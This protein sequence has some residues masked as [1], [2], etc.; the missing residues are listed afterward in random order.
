M[1]DTH[2][3]LSHIVRVEP[4]HRTCTYHQTFLKYFSHSLIKLK[5]IFVLLDVQFRRLQMF[6][7]VLVF[8][9]F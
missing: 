2:M 3:N 1:S 8:S 9:I 5:A 6:S 4:H 7:E